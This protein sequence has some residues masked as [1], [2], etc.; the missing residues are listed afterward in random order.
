MQLPHFFLA[1][2]ENKAKEIEKKKKEIEKAKHSQKTEKGN[3]NEGS[4]KVVEERKSENLSEVDL[5]IQNSKS[6]NQ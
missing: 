2:N 6:A 5:H 4:N 3:K 1:M